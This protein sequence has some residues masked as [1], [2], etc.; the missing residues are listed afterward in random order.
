MGSRT[1]WDQYGCM[2]NLLRIA[3]M[4]IFGYVTPRILVGVGMPLDKWAADMG[5]WLD[6]SRP[7]I[8]EWGLTAFGLFLAIGLSA[9]EWWWRPTQRFWG[10][11]LGRARSSKGYEFASVDFD[12]W[13][14]VD[15]LE[16][17][18][19]GCLWKGFKPHY[20]IPFLDPAYPSFIRLMNAAKAEQ[21]VVVNTSLQI[22]A[23]SFVTR[24][25]LTRFACSKG[26]MPEFLKDLVLENRVAT[27]ID[28]IPLHD[29]VMDA[30][31]RIRT[32]PEFDTQPS[33]S[34]EFASLRDYYERE[35]VKM[36]GIAAQ[37]IFN[38][39]DPPVP[40]E[41]MA[42]PR[43]A[44]EVIPQDKARGYM[45][46]DDATEMFDIFDRDKAAEQRRR[47]TNLRVKRIN[48]ERR[49]KTIEEDNGN[50]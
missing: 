12:E 21:F 16:I 26:E 5:A 49:V 13:R 6:V 10:N 18:R 44:M 34:P 33:H 2:L 41:G 22:D 17:W 7:W 36:P 19:A 45:F 8:D 9:I 37:I 28:Y 23:H 14:E 29:A 50:R 43:T 47:Y 11:V 3:A 31:E 38:C 27:D 39:A 35:P 20:P 40:I 48:I 4:G 30:W 32:L 24:Q 1:T 15:P 46:S 25:E 42:P